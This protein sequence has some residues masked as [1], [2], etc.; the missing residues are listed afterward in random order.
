M[1][2]SRAM[3]TGL[4]MTVIS[5]EAAYGHSWYPNECCSE[6][7]CSPADALFIDSHGDTIVTAGMSRLIVPHGFH[8][9]PSPDNRIHICFS[10]S[11]TEDVTPVYC[12]FV[13]GQS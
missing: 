12:V 6:G 2:I 1:P 5:Q 10:R 7:D 11:R 4:F 8:F 9:R 3:L 13:P